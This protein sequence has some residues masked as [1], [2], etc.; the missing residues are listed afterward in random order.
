VITLDQLA[1]HA[2]RGDNAYESRT[3]TASRLAAEISKKYIDLNLL[4]SVQLCFA[5][6]PFRHIG[7]DCVLDMILKR[8]VRDYQEARVLARFRKA[9]ERRKE[10]ASSSAQEFKY[11]DI[12]ERFPSEPTGEDVD[13]ALR[14]DPV[15]A[16]LKAWTLIEAK[17]RGFNCEFAETNESILKPAFCLA[18][19]SLSG[20][21][22]SMVMT[23]I[24]SDL[25][26]RARLTANDEEFSFSLVCVH[27]NY[28]NR[29]ESNAEA[30]FVQEWCH[31]RRV[32]CE[33]LQMPPELRR[34]STDRELYEKEA[35]EL[36][37]ALYERV[38][39]EEKQSVTSQTEPTA[40]LLGHHKGDVREN[41][42][43]NLMRGVDLMEL[44]GMRGEDILHGVRV[45]RPLISHLK[46]DIY[47]IAH[48]LGIPYF[49]DTTPDWS[50]RGKLRNKLWPLL[51]EIYGQGCGRNLDRLAAQAEELRHVLY[52]RVLHPGLNATS[53]TPFGIRLPCAK[54]INEDNF[55]WRAVLRESA[56]RLG[57]GALS[58][59]AINIFRK[60]LVAK[61]G[62]GWLE[63]KRSWYA[64]LDERCVFFLFDPRVFEK[65]Q[66]I[67]DD[68]IQIQHGLRLGHWRFEI[69]NTGER[70]E[71]YPT[72][73]DDLFETCRIAYDLELKP[74]QCPV[75][76]TSKVYPHRNKDNNKS[77]KYPD[78]FKPRQALD[79]LTKTSKLRDVTPLVINYDD[80]N[81]STTTEDTSISRRI[82]VK[83]IFDP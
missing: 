9:T 2:W 1:R 46:P 21:V 54:F 15:C 27:V 35:R 65:Y 71:F 32:R 5:L 66:Q 74:G 83:C 7:D 49:K 10:T 30:Q 22:D 73:L 63:L 8:Q 18:L 14:E 36:R 53:I 82:R 76:L 81:K 77:K 6:M 51:T 41:C 79:A 28:G 72:D 70:N 38:L 61:T 29:A 31:T 80:V 12:L 69:T 68:I 19:V 75:L 52:S 40:V 23:R 60:R 62:P 78:K 37:F 24:L 26:D 50:T 39:S 58:D 17:K 4:S 67:V 56:H 13:V 55:F 16:T 45:A 42:V 11:V 3:L 59:K 20:G 43:S 48:R 47:Q 34:A 57:L 33:L 44:G 64:Y 25:R